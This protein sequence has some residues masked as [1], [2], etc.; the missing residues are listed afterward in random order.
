MSTTTFTVNGSASK[1]GR[2][3]ISPDA[4]VTIGK[5][6]NGER[7]GVGVIPGKDGDALVHEHGP[8]QSAVPLYS[9]AA[10][11]ATGRVIPFEALIGAIAECK[12]IP[13][14]K[15]ALAAY[16]KEQADASK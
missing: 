11:V 16:D 4:S 7:V 13:A 5:P 9:V 10:S 3:V 12:Q 14:L 8:A 1:R 15:K 2:F 6:E